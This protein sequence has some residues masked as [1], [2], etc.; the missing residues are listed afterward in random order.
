M[1][2]P[3]RS[4][5]TKQEARVMDR[6]TWSS[7]LFFSSYHCKLYACPSARWS[8]VVSVNCEEIMTIKRKI[9]DLLYRCLRVQEMKNRLDAQN[10][11]PNLTHP[12]SPNIDLAPAPLLRF[13]NA[14]STV[15]SVALLNNVLQCLR[16]RSLTD[17]SC[18]STTQLVELINLTY[19][20][21]RV[22]IE[23][24]ENQRKK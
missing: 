4:N 12:H 6:K 1:L 5:K 19:L 15:G 14:A 10:C 23:D 8:S 16:R 9:E 17:I 22:R 2:C 7:R 3:P 13:S 21:K 18:V 11:L 24:R 20:D